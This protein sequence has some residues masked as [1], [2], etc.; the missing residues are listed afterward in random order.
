[1][2]GNSGAITAQDVAK[3]LCKLG[4]SK[5]DV[6]LFHSDLKSLAPPRELVKLP[7]CG[8]DVVIDGFLEAVGP[9]GVVVAPTLSATFADRKGP[10]QYAYDPATT[11][12]RVGSITELFRKRPGTQRSIHPTHS[13]TALGNRAAEFVGAPA[14]GSTFDI[15]GPYRR[16]YDWDGYI[17]FFGTYMRT[18]TML[19]AVEDWMDLPYMMEA[20][21]L[22]KGADGEPKK[23]TV[24]KSPGGPRDF[25]RMGSKAERY[26]ETKGFIRKGQIGNAV[27]QLMS[28]RKLVDYTWQGIIE[29][30]C[31]LLLTDPNADEWSKQMCEQT[32]RHVRER[33]GS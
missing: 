2:G 3:G 21:A 31:L 17:C 15:R 32:T 27:V 28:A 8:A 24:T 22:V 30:P 19:H 5:G 16:L 11:P 20:Q 6:V 12:S 10:Q 4:L 18:C 14:D 29:D 13:L 7:N 23:V 25:Y 9:E 33:F 26:L 1:M